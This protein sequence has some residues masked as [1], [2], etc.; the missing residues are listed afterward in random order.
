M[1]NCKAN[2]FSKIVIVIRNSEGRGEG[3]LRG[4]GGGGWIF[5]VFVYADRRP[6]SPCNEIIVSLSDNDSDGYENVT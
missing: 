3:N 6:P 2:K 4:L 1:K 5:E